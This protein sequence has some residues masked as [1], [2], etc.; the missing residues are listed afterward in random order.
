LSSWSIDV[1]ARN[2]D[3]PGNLEAGPN[4]LEG[5]LVERRLVDRVNLPR[6]TE[7]E[8]TTMQEREKK[9]QKNLSNKG[10]SVVTMSE[11]FSLQGGSHWVGEAD[12]VV[13]DDPA[14]NVPL[15]V[16]GR[17]LWFH[18]ILL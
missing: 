7:V 14:S 2:H 17:G 11:V 3:S 12:S 6:I 13:G 15:L 18:G 5:L 8:T 1:P 10:S 9:T 4:V 16:S